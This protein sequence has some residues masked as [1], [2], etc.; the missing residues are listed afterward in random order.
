MALWGFVCYRWVWEWTVQQWELLGLRLPQRCGW[1]KEGVVHDL[2]PYQN[3]FMER[4]SFVLTSPG[5]MMKT[6][7][8]EVTEKLPNKYSCMAQA[9]WWGSKLLFSRGNQG[10]DNRK[11]IVLE[12]SALRFLIQKYERLLSFCSNPELGSSK[13]WLQI[14]FPIWLWDSCLTYLCLSFLICNGDN[15]AYFPPYQRF[16]SF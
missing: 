14:S 3:G 1:G 5:G 12:S 16:R 4:N 15:S 8:K 10:L 6:K 11:R 7:W 9:A 13:T 2:S